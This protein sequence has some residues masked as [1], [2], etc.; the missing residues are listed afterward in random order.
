[1]TITPAQIAAWERFFA[2]P[3]RCRKDYEEAWGI[4]RDV[5]AAFKIPAK[6]IEELRELEKMV[7]MVANLRPINGLTDALARLDARRE[8]EAKP[9]DYCRYP[10]G[11]HGPKCPERK[12]ARTDSTGR[13]GRK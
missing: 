9:C 8:V 4:G 2:T 11:E 13:R 12:A 3:Q 5:F 10:V 7:R 6:E 1:M